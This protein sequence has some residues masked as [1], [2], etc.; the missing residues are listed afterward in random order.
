[1]LTEIVANLDCR[2]EV[3][4][5]TSLASESEE[6]LLLCFAGQRHKI[7][8]PRSVCPVPSC[9]GDPDRLFDTA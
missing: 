6:S 7:K 4:G 9:E 8:D 5:R 3:V 1:M 2:K